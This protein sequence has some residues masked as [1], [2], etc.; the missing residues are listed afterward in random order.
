M[1]KPLFLWLAL[2]LFT[3][4]SLLHYKEIP[5][6]AFSS[7]I[8]HPA[9]GIRHPASGIQHPASSIQ[10][11]VSSI[12]HPASGIQHPASSIQH[13]ASP[14]DCKECH[15]DMMTN[16]VPH[17]PVNE[18]CLNCHIVDIAGHPGIKS[19][20]MLLK[21]KAPDLCF[22]CHKEMK[23]ELSLL[24]VKHTAMAGGCPSCHKSHGSDYN[25]MLI[26]SYPKEFYV[27]AKRD[28]FAFCFECHDS[29]L[30]ELKK[31]STATNFRTGERNLHFVHM[32]GEKARNC[33]S[34]HD[35]HASN[36]KYIIVDKVTFGKW[37]FKMN[38]T[39]TDSGGS[40]YPGCHKPELY[41]R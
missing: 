10:Y 32:N 13:P 20:N 7:S 16:A 34:C 18:D 37:E 19:G 22:N 6:V 35:V 39:P 40:C 14:P 12:Q 4:L 27:P 2:P 26:S 30:L 38:F 21:E 1:E 41:Y 36:N 11:P 25:Y 17:D 31:T 3:L 8:H 9:S 28:T 29:D 23:E 15:K 33:S 5:N 24:P